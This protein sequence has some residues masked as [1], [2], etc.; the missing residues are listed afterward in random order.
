MD[1]DPWEEI[2]LERYLDGGLNIWNELS[3]AIEK[4][5]RVYESFW[6]L[7]NSRRPE[8]LD[9]EQWRN[10]KLLDALGKKFV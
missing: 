5:G 9:E 7:G 10:A 3:E 1:L 4:W 6:G 2:L 8:H